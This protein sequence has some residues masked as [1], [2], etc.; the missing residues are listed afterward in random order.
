MLNLYKNTTQT[1]H[2]SFDKLLFCQLS[3]VSG[4]RH[5]E[6]PPL[7]RTAN[8]GLLIHHISAVSLAS[9]SCGHG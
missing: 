6:T 5:D 2:C 8:G 1:K 3:N 7:Q 4:G 9:Q